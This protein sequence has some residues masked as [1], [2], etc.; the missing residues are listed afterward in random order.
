MGEVIFYLD[1]GINDDQFR[2]K[3]KSNTIYLQIYYILK[4][5][6]PKII[7]DKEHMDIEVYQKLVE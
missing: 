6:D 4:H 3:S 7:G 1:V 5:F 2:S